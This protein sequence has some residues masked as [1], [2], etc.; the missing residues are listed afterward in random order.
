MHCVEKVYIFAKPKQ[1]TMAD[2]IFPKG[3]VSFAKHANAPDFVLGTVVINP[4]ELIGWLKENANLMTDY[5]GE[6]QIRFQLTMSKDGRPSFAVDT[7]KK[8]EAAPEADNS[9]PSTDGLVF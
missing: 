6:K 7:Y 3:I 5:K 9:I 2:K 1:T 8:P 4:N